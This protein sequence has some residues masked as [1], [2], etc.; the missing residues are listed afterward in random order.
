MYMY[1]LQLQIYFS[2]LVGVRLGPFH[3]SCRT[4][5]SLGTEHEIYWQVIGDEI[6][7]TITASEASTFYVQ[8][9]E[10]Q[11]CCIIHQTSK[12]QS[13]YF[14]TVQR[15]FLTE[16]PLKLVPNAEHQDVCFTLINT[17]KQPVKVPQT[18]DEWKRGSPFYIKLPK[19]GI[20]FSKP[21]RYISVR[22]KSEKW[23]KKPTSDADSKV[24]VPKHTPASGA[25]IAFES[26]EQKIE[27]RD[28]DTNEESKHTAVSGE[29]PDTPPPPKS[30]EAK[31]TKEMQTRESIIEKL[32]Y[33][34]G[35]SA[36]L[37]TADKYVIAMQF[38]FTPVENVQG[39]RVTISS[40]PPPPPSRIESDS[41]SGGDKVIHV[42]QE[43]DDS[44]DVRLK[45]AFIELVGREY[46]FPLPVR[47]VDIPDTH[48]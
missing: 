41:A 8:S 2:L 28:S 15:P 43:E 13:Q 17:I 7:G 29:T 6:Y 36:T 18:E 23:K 25:I 48:T 30:E 47:A 3:V 12:L 20:G 37:E 5:L 19:T 38:Y 22:R 10:E 40:G 42:R 27:S 45:Q 32:K 14:A 39:S 46:V 11:F 4:P 9:N 24:E 16:C 31:E 33:T 44:D 1:V 21:T 34:T 26:D 35:S